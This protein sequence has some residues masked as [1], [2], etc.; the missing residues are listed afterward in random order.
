MSQQQGEENITSY[1]IKLYDVASGN[2][3][4]IFLSQS[5]IES[6]AFNPDG[7]TIASGLNDG[8]IQ[9]WDASSGNLIRTLAGHQSYVSDLTYS[10]DGRILVS[11]SN[12]KTIK[13]WAME[14]GSLLTTITEKQSIQ[15]ISFTADGEELIVRLNLSIE[16]DSLIEASIRNYKVPGW[17]L[18]QERSTGGL[19]DIFGAY[20]IRPNGQ[21]AFS[22][23]DI[24]S[25]NDGKD[26]SSSLVGYSRDE[27]PIQV[28]GRVYNVILTSDERQLYYTLDNNII[29]F[30]TINKRE[31]KTL[32]HDN[33]TSLLYNDVGNIV[34]SSSSDYVVKIWSTNNLNNIKTI[35][36]KPKGAT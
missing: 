34:V 25:D 29:V 23:I 5:N 27:Q 33:I 9:L 35:I 11:A 20:F 13:A 28:H 21:A 3:L 12:D 30:D 7:K 2:V 6:L 15:Q 19:G 31:I 17:M 4:K 22:V 18:S 14:S 36:V 1:N 10:P 8:T 24:A 32:P 26:I 16:S